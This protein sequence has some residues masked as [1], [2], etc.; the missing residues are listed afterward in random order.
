MVA[1]ACVVLRKR[2]AIRETALTDG[3]ASDSRLR[4]CLHAD[5]YHGRCGSSVVVALAF[6]DYTS[7]T[8]AECKIGSRADPSQNVQ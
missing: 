8:F 1:G 4:T 2:G 3:D 6:R 7:L 5:I